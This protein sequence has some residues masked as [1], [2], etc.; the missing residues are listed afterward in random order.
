MCKITLKMFPKTI[1]VYPKNSLNQ[2][3]SSKKALNKTEEKL[4]LPK[5][6]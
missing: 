3:Y 2:V 1:A 6:P 5:K 4:N